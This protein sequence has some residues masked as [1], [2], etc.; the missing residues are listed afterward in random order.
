MTS[1][2]RALSTNNNSEEYHHILVTETC[3]SIE[4][5]RR[6]STVKLPLVKYKNL[7]K[8]AKSVFTSA[9]L[10]LK[11]SQR[12]RTLWLSE[13]EM[14]LAQQSEK[15]VIL[16][17]FWNMKKT[18]YYWP[19]KRKALVDTTVHCSHTFTNILLINWTPWRIGIILKSLC[20]FILYTNIN[21][22][23]IKIE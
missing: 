16:T 23:S 19:L 7:Y 11:E 21:S 20:Q 22:S 2:Q 18:H 1:T 14:F 4:V 17:A 12:R 9:C 8:W 15:K 5:F 3:N 13:I 6:I 10:N